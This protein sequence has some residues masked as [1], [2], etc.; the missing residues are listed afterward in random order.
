MSCR[1][2]PSQLCT[3]HT[4][5][6]PGVEGDQATLLCSLISHATVSFTPHERTPRFVLFSPDP[7]RPRPCVDLGPIP[8]FI[9]AF[10]TPV[11]LG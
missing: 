10:N 9:L 6:A 4:M 2:A 7:S 1:I 8:A 3:V 11:A 5:S